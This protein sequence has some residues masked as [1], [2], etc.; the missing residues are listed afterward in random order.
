MAAASL[1]LRAELGKPRQLAADPAMVIAVAGLVLLGIVIVASASISVAESEYG[2]PFFFLERHLL[3][4]G[5]GLTAGLAALGVP[6]V[7]WQRGS[8]VA[9][10]AA[11]ALLLVVLLPGVGYEVNGSVR[12]L[13]LGIMNLQV[14][15]PARLLLMI[16]LCA[17]LVRFRDRLGASLGCFLRPLLIVAAACGLLLAQPDFGAAS[18]LLATCLGIMFLAGVR[19][20]HFF[21]LFVAASAAMAALAFSSDYRLQRIK[22]FLDPWADPNDT[23]YQLTQSLIAIGRG[24]W[25]G[26]GLGGSVQKLF[27]LPEAHTDFVFAVLAEEAGLLG[28]AAVLLL[29]A[30]LVWRSLALANAAAALGRH[31]QALVAGGIGI[32]IGLQASVNIG[33]NMGLLPTKGLT[34]PL[35]SYGGSS[36]V[37]TL[38]ALGM[39]FRIRHEIAAAGRSASCRQPQR[40]RKR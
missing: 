4:L 18:V 36:L 7:W 19:F 31:F 23:G 38:A 1:D 8:L 26:V 12:W 30:L 33:V 20:T 37:V 6:S 34:L 32:W 40:G 24:H 3:H 2:D 16:Y 9:L 11:F 28:V 15:E 5:V 21:L 35:L 14:S 13:R 25:S 27:Y 39:L 29:F 22:G 10:I 17:Y